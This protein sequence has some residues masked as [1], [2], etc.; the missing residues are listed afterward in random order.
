[1]L[2]HPTVYCGGVAFYLYFTIVL[3]T[4]YGLTPLWVALSK[5]PSGIAA[6]AVSAFTARFV[7]RWGGRRVVAA[8]AIGCFLGFLVM[9]PPVMWVR[10]WT[11]AVWTLPGQVI[12]GVG[13]GLVVAPLLGVVLASIR[14]ADA[15]AASGLL[16]TAQVS[17]VALG[18]AT[19]GL[20]FQARLPDTV[21]S[22]TADQLSAGLTGCL[23]FTLAAFATAAALI[24]ALPKAPQPA[25]RS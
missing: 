4:G 2:L 3:Q 24:T 21:A 20:L 10:D 9:L 5:V 17:G 6:I 8:G 18:V 1:V 15:G 23:Y 11:L 14:S 12:V 16:S 13:F 19:T 25:V 7:R 22:A